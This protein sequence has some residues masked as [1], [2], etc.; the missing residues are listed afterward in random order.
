MGCNYPLRA[1]VLGTKPDGKKILKI[2]PSQ[3]REG[4]KIYPNKSDWIGNRTVDLT[5]ENSM[6]IPC[7][8]CIGCRMSYAREWA[9]RLLLERTQHDTSC[10]LTLT[11][12]N[13]H[14][15][16]LCG[17]SKVNPETGE[18]EKVSISLDKR[19]TQLFMKRLRKACP[20]DKIRFYAVGEYGEES[21]RPHYHL[22]LF[23][24]HFPPGD[25]V[26]KRKSELKHDY[27]ESALIRRIWP[28]GNNIVAACTWESCC[29]CARYMLKKLKGP[30]AQLYA[31]NDLQPP[32]VLMSRKPGIGADAYHRWR[33]GYQYKYVL[34]DDDGVREFP[35]PKY[36]E[37]K[38]E[39]DFPE[40]ALE[41][42][43][44]RRAAALGIET[45]VNNLTD[46]NYFEYLDLLEK[47]LK[48]SEKTLDFYRDL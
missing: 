27:Y 24:L 17:R 18:L 5:D 47:N 44:T 21:G 37:K 4:G 42:K 14:I 39:Q 8:K 3:Y 9:N 10:F 40:F 2:L 29:Y 34:G 30:E 45:C 20:D 7:G 16:D 15:L 25:L 41:R 31:D 43:E 46:Y 11:I 33:F 32:F 19:H 48:N 23:G 22:I 6:L 36:F 38:F 1:Y 12:D 26:W 13:D 35:A 28:Y